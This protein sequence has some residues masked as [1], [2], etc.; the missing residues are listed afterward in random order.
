MTRRD[1]DLGTDAVR[2][3]MKLWHPNCWNI[4]VTEQGDAGILGH[5]LYGAA[6]GRGYTRLTVYGDTTATVEDAIDRARAADDT[7][8]VYE[9]DHDHGRSRA[10]TP[11]NAARDLLVE[12]SL[13]NQVSSAFLARGFVY[14]DPIDIRGGVERWSVLTGH[15]RA[16]ITR[17]LDEIRDEHDA[18]IEVT[19]IREATEAGTSGTLPLR[20]LSER[21]REVFQL[22]RRRGYYAHPSETAPED[23]AAELDITTSTLHEHLHKAEQKLLHDPIHEA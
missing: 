2:V 17:A 14:A 11:G 4:R 5:G 15:D 13:S 20:C 9:A 22:A 23:L 6:D 8:A 18:V 21:Q 1:A 12:R 7:Y 3:T 10:T 16:T 19:S